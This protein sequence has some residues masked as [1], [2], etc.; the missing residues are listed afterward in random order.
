MKKAL[1][2]CG[3]VGMTFVLLLG[4]I[5]QGGKT[6]AQPNQELRSGGILITRHG[7]VR[8]LGLNEED[9][10]ALVYSEDEIPGFRCVP[11]P[12]SGNHTVINLD[13]WGDRPGHD[14]KGVY[15]RIMRRWTAID[16]EVKVLIDCVIFPSNEG[17]EGWLKMILDPIA[18]SGA[19]NFRQGSFSGLPLGDNC[20]RNPPFNT[21]FFTVGRVGVIVQIFGPSEANGLFAEALGVGIEYFIRL[22]PKRLVEASKPITVLVANQ[23]IAQGKAISLSGVTVAPISALEPAKVSIKTNR[24][25]KEWVVAATRNGRWVKVKAFSWEMETNR[26]KV[27]LERPVFPYKGELIVPLRQVAE[28]LGISV[29]Q[30]GQTIALLPK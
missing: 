9:M 24:T 14:L 5:G 17:A 12:Y 6:V 13:A 22:H 23:P 3:F 28:A 4:V 30:K 15:S 26:G 21:L 2:W 20:W 27:K 11:H 10:L 16:R 1:L 8:S 19:I 18:S 29:H 25:S 7:T